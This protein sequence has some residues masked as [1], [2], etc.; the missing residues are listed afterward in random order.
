MSILSSSHNILSLSFIFPVC[1]NSS[2]TGENRC[3]T[4]YFPK[5]VSNALND[6]AQGAKEATKKAKASA[7]MYCKAIADGDEVEDEGEDE[8][9][10]SMTKAIKSLVKQLKNN[11]A[12][13]PYGS[14]TSFMD[15]YLKPIWT[16]MLTSGLDRSFIYSTTDGSHYGIK[17][18][19][20]IGVA[21]R[22]NPLYF[23]FVEVKRPAETSC[24]QEESDFVKLLKEM[25]HSIN[26]QLVLGFNDP[27]S[28]GLLVEG[29]RCSLFRMFLASEGIYMSVLLKRF[30]LVE[31][32]NDMINLPSV[33][34]AFDFVKE[35]LMVL[36][37]DLEVPKSKKQ[38]KQQ[39]KKA[40]P[41]FK[42]KFVK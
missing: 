11:Q 2:S 10:D 3:I 14:E 30:L 21:Q 17:P 15:K 6:C 33:V 8:D 31:E 12:N 40:R 38:K 7:I 32:T 24:Y 37:D 5:Q 29:F 26:D 4:R 27:I 28:Y 13:V 18:D 36:K 19:F 42:T 20:M 22:K 16:Q 23:F 34:E 9:Q 39:G 1:D 35:K 41:S 25:K